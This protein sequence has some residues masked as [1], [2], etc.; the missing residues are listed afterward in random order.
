[1][2]RES[3]QMHNFEHRLRNKAMLG[4]PNYW[5]NLLRPAVLWFRTVL[6]AFASRSQFMIKTPRL[7]SIIK[8]CVTYAEKRNDTE[9]NRL[10]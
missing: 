1:M 8:I 5:T 7:M 9:D 2:P 3:R 6:N 4:L 10:I